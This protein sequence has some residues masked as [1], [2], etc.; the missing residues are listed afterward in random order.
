MYIGVA[1]SGGVDSLYAL[2]R[3]KEEGHNVLALHG[4]FLDSDE[5]EQEN[6][7]IKIRNTI[8][9]LHI[10][11]EVLDLR[12]AFKEK[13][14]DPSLL[15]WKNGKTPNPCALCN[16]FIKFGLLF[17]HALHMGC[18][19]FATGHYVRTTIFSQPPCPASP[20]DKTKDQSYFLSLI[21]P[22]V[23]HKCCFPLKDTTKAF[24]RAW[25]HEKG[26]SVPLAQE[27]QDVCFIPGTCKLETFLEDTW[28]KQHLP[29]PEPG[30][31]LLVEAPGKKPVVIGTHKGLY[32]YT[33]GQRRGLGI[34]FREGLYVL[35]KDL[36]ANALIVGPKACLG[37]TACSGHN[38]NTFPAPQFIPHTCLVK[39]RYRQT[40]CPAE[41]S[42]S[43]D[44][45]TIRF[46]SPVFPTAQG[47]LASLLSPSGEILAG[48]LVDHID[49][50]Y[51]DM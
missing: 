36:E 48:A 14:L 47:Q 39:V 11:L 13:V 46:A 35:E 9:L 27:S 42:V 2:L 34:P 49:F 51:R 5:R 21:D 15:A 43:E 32:R 6:T 1:V 4:I 33:E 29:L 41:V 3:L 28:K 37:M 17:S 30:P 25:I 18:D 24:C 7:L 38:V 50:A 22:H 16:R 10:P 23:L 26:L 8:D 19:A 40:P 12:N 45:L 44:T 31:L 20:N